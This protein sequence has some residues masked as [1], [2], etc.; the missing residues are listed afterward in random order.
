MFGN[1]KYIRN[2]KYNGYNVFKNSKKIMPQ[3]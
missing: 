1:S 3:F 2:T